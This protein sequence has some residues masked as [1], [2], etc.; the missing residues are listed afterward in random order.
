MPAA[1]FDPEPWATTKVAHSLI[2]QEVSNNLATLNDL[3][4]Q[5]NLWLDNPHGDHEKEVRLFTNPTRY[6]RL[7]EYRHDTGEG[8]HYFATAF[9][10]GTETGVLR[11]HAL[12]FNS[13][14]SCQNMT[15]SEFP[16]ICEGARPLSIEIRRSA[17]NVSVCV[18]GEEGNPGWTRTR[19]RQ[20][21][22]E[23][24]F[25]DLSYREDR[26]ELY[27]HHL[28]NFTIHCTASTTRGYFELGNWMNNN[29]Y[30]PLLDKWPDKETIE[31]ETNNFLSNGSR[32]TET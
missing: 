23:E 5:A 19:N 30:G 28:R 1:G 27:I 7:L 6:A 3:E 20:T 21:I 10:N 31:R 26:P 16:S 32:P 9:P 2:A 12:R 11:Q 8:L 15:R 22:T 13:S 18:P 14:V 24:L 25:L 17:L 4:F 29:I